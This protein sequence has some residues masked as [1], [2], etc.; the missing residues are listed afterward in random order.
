MAEFISAV[1][2]VRVQEGVYV[3]VC[4]CVFVSR[5]ASQVRIDALFSQQL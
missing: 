3:C 2:D 5:I 4:V 1:A